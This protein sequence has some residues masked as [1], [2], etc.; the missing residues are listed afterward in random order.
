[1]KI[2]LLTNISMEESPERPS[3]VNE[4]NDNL[5]QTCSKQNCHANEYNSNY[6]NSRYIFFI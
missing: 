2:T 5:Y 1:M 6:H 4:D 3:F